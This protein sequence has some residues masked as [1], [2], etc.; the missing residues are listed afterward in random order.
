MAD[1]LF[2]R[3]P[4]DKQPVRF[5]EIAKTG[6]WSGPEQVQVHTARPDLQVVKAPV[7][8]FL[9]QGF[10]CH[11]DG[12]RFAVEMLHAAI[13]DRERQAPAGVN[14]FREARVIGGRKRNATLKAIGP[15]GLTQRAF[16]GNV[17]GD[18]MKGLDHLG[19]FAFGKKRQPDFRISRA[20]DG[21][22]LIGRDDMNV[23]SHLAQLAPY[24]FK[25]TD[26]TVDLRIPG[27][28]YDQY[29]HAVFPI[30]ASL[31]FFEE[32]DAELPASWAIRNM[33]IS[34]P[35]PSDGAL[36]AS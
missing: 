9:T 14:I 30:G 7:G 6:V 15:C 27:I 20:G 13:K 17:D 4:A 29:F 26:N 8:Q 18:R 2:H 19:H 33:E 16:G 32:P 3:N 10:G 36:A 11:H 1:I 25:G 24:G 28:G 5:R 23:M 34:L 12:L 22:K 35:R 21:F 31:P